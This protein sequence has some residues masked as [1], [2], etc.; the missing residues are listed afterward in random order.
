MEEISSAFSSV[1]LQGGA[2]AFGGIANTYRFV[3]DNE[4]V[5]KES[6]E[7]ALAKKRTHTEDLEITKRDLT[8][9][10]TYFVHVL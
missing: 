10:G 4:E 9:E 8:K 5:G 3:A 1:G 6:I 7:D 2:E